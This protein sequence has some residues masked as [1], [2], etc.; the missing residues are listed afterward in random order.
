MTL[1]ALCRTLGLGFMTTFALNVERVVFFAGGGIGGCRI[2][3]VA[4]E[5][6]LYVSLAC[7]LVVALE[8]ID[9]SRMLGVIKRHT[10]LLGSNL[11]DGDLCRGISSDSH[12]S[13]KSNGYCN[14][15]HNNGQFPC[16]VFTLLVKKM[17]ALNFTICTDLRVYHMLVSSVNQAGTIMKF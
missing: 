8:T 7:S 10:G 12:G 17:F 2:G 14:C 13:C 4:L 15:D 11:V 6:A 3:A 16:H 9:G 5:A 1:A